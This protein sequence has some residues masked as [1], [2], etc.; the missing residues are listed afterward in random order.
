MKISKD[1]TIGEVIRNYPNAIQTLSSF[2]L[3]CVGCP[4]SQV[5]T[6]E[7]ACG[8]HGLPVDDL[9]KALRETV[10]TTIK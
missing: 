4:S 10:E 2:G 9:I 3:G 1:I 6:L 8:V 7:E 5:E